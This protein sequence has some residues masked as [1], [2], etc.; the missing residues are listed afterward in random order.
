MW[1]LLTNHVEEN[2]VNDHLYMTDRNKFQRLNSYMWF[3]FFLKSPKSCRQKHRF[4]IVSVTLVARE[5]FLRITLVRE[6][7]RLIAFEKHF[8][9]KQN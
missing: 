5:N 7:Q 3:F 6:K 4:L 9:R 8:H 1:G 2:K